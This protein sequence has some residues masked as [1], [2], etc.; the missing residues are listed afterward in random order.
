M[1]KNLAMVLGLVAG[2]S[3][4]ADPYYGYHGYPHSARLL[5]CYFERAPAPNDIEDLCNGQGHL[6]GAARTS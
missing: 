4:C 3:A 1:L 6:A 2:L 5:C